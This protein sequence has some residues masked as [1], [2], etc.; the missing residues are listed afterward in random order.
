MQIFCANHLSKVHWRELFLRIFT[1]ANI[2][3]Q[4]IALSHSLNKDTNGQH[5]KTVDNCL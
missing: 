4:N 2:E 1:T 3:H 5:H